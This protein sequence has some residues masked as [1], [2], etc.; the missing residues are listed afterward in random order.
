M[1]TRD[2]SFTGKDATRESSALSEAQRDA[3]AKGADEAFEEMRRQLVLRQAAGEIP[4]NAGERAEQPKPPNF[5]EGLEIDKG[6]PKAFGHKNGDTY[7]IERDAQGRVDRVIEDMGGT[8]RA[9]KIERDEN[10]AVKRVVESRKDI[11][12][13]TGKPI[14][15]A[16]VLDASKN[17][18]DASIDK[19]G[20]LTLSKDGKAKQARTLD[21]GHREFEH[22]PDGKVTKISDTVHT[23]SGRDLVQTFTRLGNGNIFKYDSNF[24]KGGLATNVVVDEKGQFKLDRVNDLVKKDFGDGFHADLAAAREHFLEIARDKGMGNFSD[25]WCKKFETRCHDQAHRGQKSPTDEQIADTYK[26]LEKILTGSGN[27]GLSSRKLLV[28]A[29]LR[30][31]GDPNH[32]INQSDHPSCAFA[33]TERHVVGRS[34]DMHARVLYEAITNKAVRSRGGH[35]TIKLT[36]EQIK[37]EEQNVAEEKGGFGWS[38]SNKIFQLAAIEV[39]YGNNY[40]GRGY[41]FPGGTEDQTDRACRFVDGEKAMPLKFGNNF[42]SPAEIKRLLAKHGTIGL[43]DYIPGHA[44]SLTD[45]KTTSSGTYVYI[46]NSW[47]GMQQGWA[48]IG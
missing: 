41:G 38:Y 40:H 4:A 21:G 45:I 20:V 10:G 46:S 27:V 34:P 3:S 1:T 42:G 12:E 29:A 24:S 48:K 39:G 28:R 22:G 36:D 11:D 2:S 6:L 44:M 43:F 25:K 35:A 33:M 14:T 26:Y 16:T 15:I 18:D 8:E 37:P 30:E 5:R 19:D 9:Y 7:K 13:K 23:N 32:Y 31:Y 47:Q 17:F